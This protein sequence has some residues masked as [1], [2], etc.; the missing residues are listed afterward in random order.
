MNIVL[1]VRGL[2]CL[3]CL[4]LSIISEKISHAPASLFDDSALKR[5]HTLITHCVWVVIVFYRCELF[6][7]KTRYF[8]EQCGYIGSFNFQ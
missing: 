5:Q 4:V 7:V 1:Y 2:T 3:C 8:A 6:T